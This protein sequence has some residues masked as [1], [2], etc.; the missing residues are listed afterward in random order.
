M[1]GATEPRTASN[2]EQ[3]AQ[4][5]PAGAWSRVPLGLA[6]LVAVAVLGLLGSKMAAEA[7]WFRGVGAGGRGGPGIF[8]TGQLVTI[9]FRQAPDFTLRLYSGD[10]IRLADLRGQPVMVSFWASWCPP[11]RAEAPLL[12]RTWRAYRDRGVVFIGV[13]VWDSEQDARAFLREFDITYPNGPD[14]A[15]EIAIDYGL[16]G[17]PETFFVDR[18]GQIVRKW[19]GPFTDEALRA[20]LDEI[21]AAER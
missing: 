16:A 8:T 18:Q 11:C 14:T 2:D 15:G 4:Q 19:I 6:L 20:F 12:E 1:T 9:P 13:N 3:P 5:R 7:G 10:T 21:V 17:L